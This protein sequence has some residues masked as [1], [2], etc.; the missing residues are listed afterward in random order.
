MVGNTTQLPRIPDTLLAPFVSN[1][2]PCEGFPIP[3]FDEHPPEQLSF[4]EAGRKWALIKQQPVA[5][6]TIAQLR[7]LMC[8]T[9]DVLFRRAELDHNYYVHRDADDLRLLQLVMAQVANTALA[10]NI[11]GVDSLQNRIDEIEKGVRESS[12]VRDWSWGRIALTGAMWAGG[13]AGSL[14]FLSI[15]FGIGAPSAPKAMHAISKKW[16]EWRDNNDNDPKPPVSPSGMGAEGGSAA[17][18]SGADGA[19]R[20]AISQRPWQ[21]WDRSA[22]GYADPDW[23]GTALLGAA[24]FMVW[25]AL[26]GLS[27]WSISEVVIPKF[28]PAY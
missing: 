24:A 4:K 21:G 9:D 14:A 3:Y 8:D 13:V 1:G 5:S 23:V 19:A 11:S 16:R 2:G 12:D 18:G 22:K 28:A 25:E 26:P 10:H 6:H 27:E 15:A 7:W 17:S 20:V